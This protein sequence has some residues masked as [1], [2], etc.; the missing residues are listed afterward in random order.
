MSWPPGTRAWKAPRSR[1][2]GPTSSLIGHQSPLPGSNGSPAPY[3]EAALP[4]ELSGHGALGGIRTRN[5]WLLGPASL[6]CWSTSTR[7]LWTVSN[8]LPLPYEGSA[9][10]GELQRRG[11][12]GWTRTS[13]GKGQSLAGDADA[14]P[15][16]GTGGGTCT[17]MPRGLSSRGLHCRHSRVRRQSLDLRSPG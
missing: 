2:G 4:D 11:F 3:K 15:G 13:G 14:P 10:P 8:R 7:S 16:N 5:I 17:R 6:P 1:P 9:L 12:R